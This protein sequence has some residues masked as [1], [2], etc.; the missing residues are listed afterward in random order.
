MKKVSFALAFAALVSAGLSQAQL[1]DTYNPNAP[2]SSA[3]VAAGP[4]FRLP[5]AILLDQ[6]PLF[7]QAG[8]P[9][10]SIL[11]TTAAVNYCVLGYSAA[12]TNRLADDFTV[13][14]GQ[15][16][17]INSVTVFG[18][19]TGATAVSINSGTLRILS[20]S[21]GVNAAPTVVFGDTTTNRVTPAN[22]TLAGTNRVTS[23]TLTATD[24]LIQAIPLAVTP[25]LVLQPGTYWI[26]FGAAGT[27]ASGPFFPPLSPAVTAPAA[28]GNA[29]NGAAGAI[30][31]AAV[32]NLGNPTCAPG[33]TLP[34]PA[35][36]IPFIIDGTS[37]PIAPVVP[38]V[39]APSLNLFG[40]LALIGVMFGVGYV[41]SRRH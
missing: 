32:Q 17:T 23:T 12:G 9:N 6:G 24:R 26:D 38:R 15:T 41:A 27:V 30:Y 28:N 2:V 4:L 39:Q 3:P 13:P 16:W 7:T 8:T 37:A 1:L 36:G 34:G 21:P 31:P 10:L 22:V 20:T 11:N 35:H 25:G 18:Y 29:F 40:L 14:A 5:T 19:Q 33:A